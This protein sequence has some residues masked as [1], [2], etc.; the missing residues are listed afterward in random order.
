MLLRKLRE[1]NLEAFVNCHLSLDSRRPSNA[2]STT[3]IYFKDPNPHFLVHLFLCW[4]AMIQSRKVAV[5]VSLN[6][7]WSHII[8]VR[9]D[10]WWYPVGPIQSDC[11]Y[12]KVLLFFGRY[13]RWFCPRSRHE[14]HVSCASSQQ[15]QSFIRG[16]FQRSIVTDRDHFSWEHIKITV[17]VANYRDQ[18][19]PFHWGQ[20]LWQLPFI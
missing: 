5:P 10:Q 14:E 18:L 15:K 13:A 2:F 6:A 1:Q 17:W 9:Y 3:K 11:K 12:T 20:F 19:R 16:L 4:V 8:P 7:T